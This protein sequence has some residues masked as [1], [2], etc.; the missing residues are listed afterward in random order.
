MY[1]LKT[2][3]TDKD[4][5]NFIDSIEDE[6]KRE[7][8]KKLVSIFNE[9]TGLEPRMWGE[10]IIGY[11]T[12]HYKYASGHEGDAMITGFSPRKNQFSLY[13]STDPDT[14]EKL[15]NKLGKVK[16]GVA[17]VYIKS[18]DQ[19]D[20]KIIKEFIQENVDYIIKEYPNNSLTE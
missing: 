20:E 17:C 7:E 14:R 5:S 3:E 15:L 16:S 10:N 6:K 1:K 19:V 18:I 11:G 8:T 2:K 9:A 13:L 12:Y 4:V